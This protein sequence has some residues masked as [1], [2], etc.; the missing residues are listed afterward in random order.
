MGPLGPLPLPPL[1]PS[2]TPARVRCDDLRRC[3]LQMWDS[4]LRFV[5]I[6]DELPFLRQVWRK[7]FISYELGAYA[8][9]C[10]SIF[11]PNPQLHTQPL[12]HLRP[13]A[14]SLLAS[15][16]QCRS[17]GC[18]NALSPRPGPQPPSGAYASQSS[19]SSPPRCAIIRFPALGPPLALSLI[20][21]SAFGKLSQRIAPRRPQLPQAADFRQLSTP[22]ILSKVATLKG[23][24]ASVRFLQRT[25]GI[26]EIKAGEQQNPD[27]EKVGAKDGACRAAWRVMRSALQFCMM[28][29]TWSGF[30][31]ALK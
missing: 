28:A 31:I 18:R 20:P 22:E 7:L 3:R 1:S 23:E 16:S 14:P 2:F 19:L 24:I 15:R 5:K 30:A 8:L 25:R 17:A 27:P 6:D 9:P 12:S 29:F 26:S 13:S 11:I 4:K 10:H 21:T